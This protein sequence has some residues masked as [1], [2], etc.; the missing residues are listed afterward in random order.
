M[1]LKDRILALLPRR[2][3]A[4][5]DN[6]TVDDVQTRVVKTDRLKRHLTE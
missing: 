1:T 2:K 6:E 5:T 4:A 3:A